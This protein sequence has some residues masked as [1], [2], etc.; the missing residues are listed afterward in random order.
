[1]PNLTI[2]YG[3]V[4]PTYHFHDILANEPQIDVIVSGEGEATVPRLVAAVGDSHDL[5]NVDGIAIR[6]DGRIVATSPAPMIQNLDA[7]RVGWELVDLKKYS[8]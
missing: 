1:M 5:S 3:G 4:F 7:C 2:V 8:Y 6:S